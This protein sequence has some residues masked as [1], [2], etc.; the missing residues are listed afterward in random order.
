LYNFI[1]TG[2]L[3]PRDSASLKMALYMEK[4]IEVT[5]AREQRD[6]AAHDIKMQMAHQEL[7]Q[8]QQNMTYAQEMHDLRKRIL[9]EELRV[10]ENIF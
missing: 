5:M 6:Q 10:K 4:R 7:L 2:K 9:Q 8:L 3:R 1:R